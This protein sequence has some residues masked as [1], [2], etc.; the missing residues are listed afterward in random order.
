MDSPLESSRL[1]FSLDSVIPSYTTLPLYTKS[2]VDPPEWTLSPKSVPKSMTRPLGTEIVNPVATLGTIARSFPLVRSPSFGFRM[3]N[4]TGPSSTTV[5]PCKNSICTK[6]LA[7]FKLHGSKVSP[8]SGLN[9]AESSQTIPTDLVRT[10]TVS[11]ITSCTATVE[12]ESPVLDRT[13]LGASGSAGLFRISTIRKNPTRNKA[14][15]EIRGL[16]NESS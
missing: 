1:I 9:L 4:S 2:S 14:A 7:I 15:M 5:A 3:E 11:T 13:T 16:K 12:E 6:P 8:R 10:A